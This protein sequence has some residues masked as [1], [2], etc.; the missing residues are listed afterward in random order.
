[1]VQ[2][3]APN[4]NRRFV[5]LSAMKAC[6][7]KCRGVY[8]L[9]GTEGLERGYGVLHVR[10]EYIRGSCGLQ[11]WPW[12]RLTKFFEVHEVSKAIA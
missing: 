8:E 4:G 10:E 2:R 11:Y 12:A 3:V 6:S 5:L 1:M 7:S 9:G